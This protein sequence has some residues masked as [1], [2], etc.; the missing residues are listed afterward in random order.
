M[1]VTQ[2]ILMLS[3][4]GLTA[5][6]PEAQPS[7]PQ[8][9]P[10]PE[11]YLQEYTIVGLE[12]VVLPEKERRIVFKRVPGRWVNNRRIQQKASPMNV[13]H[14]SRLKPS[15]VAL[16]QV[17]RLTARV[18]YGSFNTLSADVL[19]QFRMKHVQPYFRSAFQ[20][21]EG[22][23]PGARWNRWQIGGG[24]E[25]QLW[26]GSLIQFQTEIASRNQG[27]W[28]RVLPLDS[29]WE[30]RRRVW[31][32]RL[33]V[34]QQWGGR[35][36]IDLN[37]DLTREAHI[38]FRNTTQWF[39]QGQARIEY[40][41]DHTAL[42]L[43]GGYETVVTSFRN[44]FPAGGVWADSSVRRR[45]PQFLVQLAHQFGRLA[46]QVGFRVQ[47]LQPE[48]DSAA[49][50]K[51]WPRFQATMRLTSG[52]HLT[53]S[54]DAG[55][56]HLRNQ[57]F[58]E[59]LLPADFSTYATTRVLQDWRLSLKYV[60]W[61]PVQVNYGVRYRV[62]ADYPV[63]ESNLT[64]RPDNPR[65]VLWR[66]AYARQVRLMEHTLH[67]KS[68]IKPRF[69]LDAWMMFRQTALKGTFA[70]GADV[71][72]RKVPYLTDLEA[73]LDG[74]W[75][76]WKDNYF[77]VE[78]QFIGQRYDD[79]QNTVPLQAYVRLN[80]QIRSQLGK[81]FW[82][83]LR[84]ENLLNQRYELWKTFEAPPIQMGVTLGIRF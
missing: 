24:L 19:T 36:R 62:A 59:F 16:P 7:S 26:K 73:W 74:H 12:K 60:P 66:Y 54:F 69:R 38:S 40:R 48:I 50:P 35:L 44:R 45:L 10:L 51:L 31:K 18:S 70:D 30:V 4:L 65:R 81:H 58:Y 79:L 67:L 78:I 5:S 23:L 17:H 33:H 80:A 83:I 37:G 32:G 15:I 3:F 25:G 46:F 53:G 68:D 55:Y 43:Q 84:G 75:Q 61:K 2:W 82:V 9:K 76:F 22:H 63:V 72:S 27:L 1:K 77:R 56:R 8:K 6:E 42:S 29:L 41:W 49:S 21:S 28:G 47:S 39:W 13:F 57:Y 14:F 11:I 64:P 71:Q 52:L 20:R 34:Q